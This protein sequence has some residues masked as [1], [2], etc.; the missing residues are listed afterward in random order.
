MGLGDDDGKTACGLVVMVLFAC[1]SYWS[2]PYNPISNGV[3]ECTTP[4][5]HSSPHHTTP[6]RNHSTHHHS[7][8]KIT[9]LKNTL[10]HP[11]TH[12]NTLTLQHSKRIT[13][14]TFTF[15]KKFRFFFFKHDT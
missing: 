11:P 2:I 15:T 13:H 14:H 3:K 1:S 5:K 7:T 9:T 10:Q 12:F 8:I 4:Q 6:K